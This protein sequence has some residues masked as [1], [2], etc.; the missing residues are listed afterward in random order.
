MSLH[1]SDIPMNVPFTF[2]NKQPYPQLLQLPLRIPMYGLLLL[3][4]KRVVVEEVEAVEAVVEKQ[5]QIKLQKIK[6]QTIKKL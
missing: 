3:L 4:L 5:M 1:D 2:R 6:L